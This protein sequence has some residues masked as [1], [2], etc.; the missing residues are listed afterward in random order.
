M[1]LLKKDITEAN[2]HVSGSHISQ[3]VTTE[4][5]VLTALINFFLNASSTMF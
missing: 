3:K 5:A 1:L 4:N 2:S